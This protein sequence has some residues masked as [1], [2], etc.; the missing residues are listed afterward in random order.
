M[1]SRFPE[2]FTGPRSH[3]PRRFSLQ[4]WVWLGCGALLFGL[5]SV[6]V[7]LSLG[8]ESSA[9]L[10]AGAIGG[11]IVGDIL[12]A[13]AF[14]AAAPTRVTV[15]PGEKQRDDSTIDEAGRVVSGFQTGPQGRVRIRGEIWAARRV[16]E[17]PGPLACGAPVRILGREGLTLIVTPLGDSS[18]D[19]G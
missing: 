4:W 5:L 10:L 3:V 16:G 19:A 2:R 1:F 11:S 9:L 18:V 13:L 6:P 12:M 17:D 14:E 7:L 8:L 15:G